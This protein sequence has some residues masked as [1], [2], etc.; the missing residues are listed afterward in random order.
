MSYLCTVSETVKTFYSLVSFFYVELHY[1]QSVTMP[2]HDPLTP[3]LDWHRDVAKRSND[4][5]AYDE[6]VW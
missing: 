6:A 2:C 1:Y 4:E 3:P 5:E